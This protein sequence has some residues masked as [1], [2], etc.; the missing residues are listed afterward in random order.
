MVLVAMPSSAPCGSTTGVVLTLAG[1]VELSTVTVY[2]LPPPAPL[3]TTSPV[4]W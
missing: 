3:F 1:R 2:V 4:N